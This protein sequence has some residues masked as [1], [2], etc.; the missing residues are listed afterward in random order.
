MKKYLLMCFW[1]FLLL[2]GGT[3]N[4]GFINAGFDESIDADEYW[5]GSGPVSGYNTLGIVHKS[6][7]ES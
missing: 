3:S 7:V 1:L 4:S 5:E 6:N 2:F